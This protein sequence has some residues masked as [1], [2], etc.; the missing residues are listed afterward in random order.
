M[1]SCIYVFG[2]YVNNQCTN[3]LWAFNTDRNFWKKIN[4]EFSPPA[5]AN[6]S[7]VMWTDTENNLETMII[8]GGINDNLERF[9]DV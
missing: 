7:A 3:E 1:H 2:G 6:H 5:R 8:L 4:N 9:K